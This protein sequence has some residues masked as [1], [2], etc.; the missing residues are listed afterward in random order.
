MAR[1]DDHDEV[2][3]EMVE[4][5]RVFLTESY[6]KDLHKAAEEERP[7]IVDFGKL[8]RYPDM[9]QMLLDDP[10]LFFKTA[11]EAVKGIDLPSPVKIRFI[12]LS[13]S[14]VV[15]IRD[16][17][18]R[19][20]NKL[21][22][23][24]GTVKRASEIRPEVIAVNWR[25]QECG[26]VTHLPVKGPFISKPFRCLN[27]VDGKN[28]DGK[29]FEEDKK[30]VM[31]DARWLTVEEP[32]ELTE[33]EKPSQVNVWLSED[34]VSVDGR[35][36]TDPGNRLK[37]VGI[38]R[39][40]PKTKMGANSTKLDFYLDANSVEPTETTWARL[41]ISK[42]DEENI[43][44]LAAEP[45]IYEK[46]VGSLAPS[47]Y[48]LTGIKEAI[49][50]QLFGGVARTLPDGTKFR[51]DIHILII[52]DPSSGKSQLLKL[53]PEIVPRGRYVSGKG[54]TGAGLT[55]TVTKDEQ[56]MGGWVLEAGALV[57]T[58]KGLLAIDEFEKMSEDDQVAMH[59][60]L[61]QGTISIAKASII[62]TLPARTS[63]L[64]G[65]N[66]KFSRFD[67]MRSISEQIDIPP[68]L[69]SRFDLKFTLRDVPDAK[70]DKK[71]V[72]HVMRSRHEGEQ[73]MP[74]IP[75]DLVRKYIAYAREKTSPQMS[76]EVSKL[77][78]NFYVKT[79]ARAEGGGPVPI[80]LRQFEG[81][82]RL[83]E[84]SAK[85]RLSDTIT[86]DDANRAIR[87]MTESLMN[88]GYDT[89]TGGIDVDRSEGATSFSERSKITK[90]LNLLD[91][92]SGDKK[93]IVH[94]ARLKD[95]ASKEGIDASE[96]DE[97]IERLKRDGVL[98]EPNPGYVQRP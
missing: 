81:L 97:I 62:A 82:L 50:L 15:N 18:S 75:R 93:E 13:E 20:I 25:C 28:C 36:M 17:R 71:I 31:I 88:L 34:L 77:L 1:K 6:L 23:I 11:E 29:S 4:K 74:A 53:V 65:G 52:G 32:F 33:G 76:P 24:E 19:H 59:E 41:K 37:I 47:L 27:S 73:M 39:D 10:E 78:K 44:V 85:V 35:R 57:L 54:V 83:S 67:P 40:I 22:M 38:L 55:A 58:N 8:D 42:E 51:G 95:L 84:A 80:T 63:V 12:G 61:E 91:Q 94:I 60:A 2:S 56:F 14:S 3:P 48:G 49:I 45:G 5:F 46:L 9:S 98:F 16:L 70:K 26:F 89:E 87:L 79:R 30:K 90:I 68:T 69:L 43:K 64:A 66:P 92:L 7:L 21:I 72:D 86:K 96:V